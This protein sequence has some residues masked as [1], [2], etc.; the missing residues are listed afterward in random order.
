MCEKLEVFVPPVFSPLSPQKPILSVNSDLKQIVWPKLVCGVSLIQL[1]DVVK[2]PEIMRQVV[3]YGRIKT[4]E[5]FHAPAKKMVS[6][7]E[8]SSRYSD[9]TGKS[10]TKT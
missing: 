3:A 10:W 5:N 9:L 6:L 8:M 4:M 2:S 1:E 7:T